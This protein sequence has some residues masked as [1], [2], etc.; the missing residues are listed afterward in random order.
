MMYAIPLYYVIYIFDSALTRVR[1]SDI[2]WD[3]SI[4][5]FDPPFVCVGLIGNE[6]SVLCR[7][8]AVLFRP[9]LASTG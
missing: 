6:K 1:E 7:S 3:V 2:K 4:D 8:S 5:S 9:N